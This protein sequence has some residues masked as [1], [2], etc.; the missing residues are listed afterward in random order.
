MTPYLR[1]S[2]SIPKRTFLDDDGRFFE[3]AVV[4]HEP[5]SGN[6]PDLVGSRWG[7]DSSFAVP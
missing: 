3:S 6:L 4:R 1:V 7:S 5:V 2:Y